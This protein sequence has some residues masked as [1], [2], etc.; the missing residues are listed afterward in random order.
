M[1]AGSKLFRYYRSFE[2]EATLLIFD[3]NNGSS[4]STDFVLK[5]NKEKAEVV[6][7]LNMDG[8]HCFATET[9]HI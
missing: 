6:S 2:D 3:Y 5:S 9:M 7:N 4:A 8:D 1:V